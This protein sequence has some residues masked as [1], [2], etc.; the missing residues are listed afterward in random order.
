MLTFHPPHTLAVASQ[1]Y[2]Y[3]IFVFPANPSVLATSSDM[4]KLRK[5]KTENFNMER[6]K[7]LQ[8]QKLIREKVSS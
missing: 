2:F 3:P 1:V 4:D 5:F 6:V 7:I 8:I